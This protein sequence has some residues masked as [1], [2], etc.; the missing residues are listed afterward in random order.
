MA[1]WCPEGC[2]WLLSPGFLDAHIELPLLALVAGGGA[3]LGTLLC[4][5]A[6]VSRVVYRKGKA[7]AG[8]R[9]GRGWA[10]LARRAG[11][12]WPVTLAPSSLSLQG[13]RCCHSCR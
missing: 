2:F 1:A 11:V 12:D 6:L 7:A 3:A 8:R 4:L 5:G 13:S 10:R 9:K